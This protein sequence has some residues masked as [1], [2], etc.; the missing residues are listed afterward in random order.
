M[1]GLE[2]T[3]GRDA[4]PPALPPEAG[5]ERRRA[6]GSDKGRRP[7]LGPPARIARALSQKIG[8]PSM[9]TPDHTRG[10]AGP[11]AGKRK[12]GG[13]RRGVI[14]GRRARYAHPYPT[15]LR[16]NTRRAWA[17]KSDPG[18]MQGARTS[19]TNPSTRSG[20]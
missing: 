19:E 10:T 5:P 2:G 11:V 15:E 1:A 3:G 9:R 16:A 12:P 17:R 18:E 7:L 8:A 6:G 14:A 20:E 13:P 4:R